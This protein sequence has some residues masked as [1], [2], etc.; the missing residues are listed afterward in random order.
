MFI[1]LTYDVDTA[2]L[3]K[4]AR[5]CQN[6][7]VRV[8]NS[9]FEL[10]VTQK[11]LIDLKSRLSVIIQGDDSVRFYKVSSMAADI[12]ILGRQNRIEILSDKAFIL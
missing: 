4:V 8:Q 2:R 7:G 9:V 1:V 5:V 10:R 11:Q 6:Y 3:P 12:E